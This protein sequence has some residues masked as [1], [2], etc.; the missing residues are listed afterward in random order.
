MDRWK[1]VPVVVVEASIFLCYSQKW[2]SC[3]ERDILERTH[4][5]PLC[6]CV[7]RGESEET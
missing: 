3:R 5:T 6:R 1:T 4:R 7:M 2:L